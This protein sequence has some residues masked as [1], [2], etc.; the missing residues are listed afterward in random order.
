MLP[1]SSNTLRRPASTSSSTMIRSRKADV[2]T[3][4][5]RR[6]VAAC[7]DGTMRHGGAAEG[8]HRHSLV[9]ADAIATD[10]R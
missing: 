6:S 7:R 10:P 5:C 8:H 3:N 1:M 2:T 4:V 9:S